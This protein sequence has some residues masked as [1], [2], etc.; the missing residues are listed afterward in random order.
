MYTSKSQYR[1]IITVLMVGLS[2]PLAA[3]DTGQPGWTET[4]DKWGQLLF[5]QHIYKMPEVQSRLYS[6]DIDQCDK[7]AQLM[8]KSVAKYS[9]REQ[10]QLQYQAEQHAVRL[11]RYTSEPYQSVP[12][13]REYCSELVE[14]L[15]KHSD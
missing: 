10:K 1:L 8:A 14:T 5:C 7:A 12:A 4:K 11:S 3:Q 9:E 13:C 6:F 2:T 15:D